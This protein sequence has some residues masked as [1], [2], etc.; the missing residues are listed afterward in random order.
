MPSN[1]KYLF[2]FQFS[3]MF[4]FLRNVF[5]LYCVFGFFRRCCGQCYFAFLFAGSF[6]LLFS[7]AFVFAFVFFPERQPHVCFANNPRQKKAFRAKKK[8]SAPKKSF[9]RQKRAFRAKKKLSAPK[10]SFPRQ[11]KGQPNKFT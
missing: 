5:V 8:L 1:L 6:S 3:Y 9:P 4:S 7:F 11:K 10:K 2:G